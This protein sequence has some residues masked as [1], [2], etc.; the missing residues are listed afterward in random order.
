MTFVCKRILN[1]FNKTISHAFTCGVRNDLD[2]QIYTTIFCPGNVIMTCFAL[3]TY[4]ECGKYLHIVCM[5]LLHTT[6]Q[7]T[8]T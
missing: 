4:A 1:Q 6:M 5:I 8:V 3:K 7:I 2:Q